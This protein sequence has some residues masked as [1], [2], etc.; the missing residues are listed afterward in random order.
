MII[1]ANNRLLATSTLSPRQIQMSTVLHHL[2]QHKIKADFTDDDRD[3]VVAKATTAEVLMGLSGFGWGVTKPE[4][5]VGGIYCSGEYVVVSAP[6]PITV[7]QTSVERV[8][9]CLAPVQ[10]TQ[11]ITQ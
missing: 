5:I 6:I 4:K 2:K 7:M 3:M 8:I 11:S 1:K 9:I 10:P